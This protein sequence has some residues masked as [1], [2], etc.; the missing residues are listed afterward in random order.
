MGL[1][2]SPVTWIVVEPRYHDVV[3]STYGRGLYILSDITVL[4]QTGQT[5]A[6]PVT[7][8]FPPKAG[9]RQARSGTAEFLYS[10]AAAPSAAGQMEILDAAGRVI[11]KQELPQGAPG[12]QSRVVEPDLR[13]ADAR[14]DA[15]DADREPAHLG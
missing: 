12:T 8:L 3:V 15:D 2:P 13:A 10:L 4:E 11:R 6:P 5:T 7:Q 1:P 9:I 14:R